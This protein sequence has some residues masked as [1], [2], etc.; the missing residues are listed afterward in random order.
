MLV[1]ALDRI[2]NILAKIDGRSHVKAEE[3]DAA[4]GDYIKL[5][6]LLCTD[7]DTNYK[8][9]ALLK[10]LNQR[11]KKAIL[12]LQHVNNFHRLLKGWMERFQGV[13]TLIRQLPLLV[14]L[15]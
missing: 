12:H 15:A 8:K 5:T 6:F 10:N 11:V 14:S 1:V 7:T 4:I 9:Y 2:G 3:I 13:G